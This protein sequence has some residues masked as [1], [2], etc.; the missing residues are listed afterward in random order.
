MRKETFLAAS[1][2][3]VLT[4]HCVTRVVDRAF[5][6][7]AL[8]KNVFVKMMRE[9]EAFCGVEVLTYCVMSNYIHLLGR[10]DRS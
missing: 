3:G 1:E 9:Y 4:F 8:E 10:A 6:L 5:K 7:G 2:G